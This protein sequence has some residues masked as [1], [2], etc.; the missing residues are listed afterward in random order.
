MNGKIKSTL[1][2]F[3]I[4]FVVFGQSDYMKYHQYI[5]KA[6]SLFGNEQFDSA[7][8][9][10]DSVFK[11][12]KTAFVRDYLI[13]AQIATLTNSPER[14]TL[15][16]EKALKWG[17]PCNCV[18][19][20]PVF[21][22]YIKLE[23]WKNLKS[24]EALFQKYYASNISIKL[25]KEFSIRYRDEQDSKN[26]KD[27]YNEVVMSNYNR[28]KFLMDSLG[29]PSEHII[30]LD[31]GRIA[32]NKRNKIS[33]LETCNPNNQKVIAT[34]LHYDNPITDIGI[35]KFI[36]AIESGL[37]HPRD[38]AYIL[39]F[40]KNYISRIS[41]SKHVNKVNLLDYNFNFPF[42]KRREDKQKI[43][44]DRAKFGIISLEIEQ[45]IKRVQEKYKFNIRI[46][47]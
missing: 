23:K 29:F 21:K 9:I 3:L 22:D 24:K 10:Y 41:N 39:T 2:L 34:L 33:G 20:L 6:D 12:F 14:I 43:N 19:I 42:E 8:N 13:A 7:L 17:Y 1:F 37:L 26:Q 44:T 28:I 40:E 27:I 35:K 36:F 45:K 15:Y 47:Y 18:E 46:S 31:D 4:P 25:N 32:P 30:G 38:F 11:E 5:K 16:L